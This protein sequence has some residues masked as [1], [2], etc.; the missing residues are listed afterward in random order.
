M[1]SCEPCMCGDPACPHCGPL[2]GYPPPCPKCH[3]VDCDCAPVL[4]ADD[5]H[6]LHGVDAWEEAHAAWRD[7]E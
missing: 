2:Q 3:E 5:I 7:E 4:D 6:D 1:G